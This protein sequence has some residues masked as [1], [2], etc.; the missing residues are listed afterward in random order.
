MVHVSPGRREATYREPMPPGRVSMSSVSLPSRRSATEYSR[1]SASPTWS[2]MYWPGTKGMS[3]SM[4]KAISLT[5]SVRHVEEMTTAVRASRGRSSMEVAR[6]RSA[7]RRRG[8]CAGR[9][10]D[11][12]ESPEADRAGCG[13]HPAHQGPC[14]AQ[15]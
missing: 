2:L 1:H 11:A 12:H 3:W 5:V 15:R 10:D 13:G 14:D 4:R 8:G 6:L 7:C 9:G